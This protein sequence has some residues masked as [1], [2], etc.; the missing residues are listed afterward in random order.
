MEHWL[1]RA[2]ESSDGLSQERRERAQFRKL[3]STQGKVKL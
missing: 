1:I 2:M 3:K